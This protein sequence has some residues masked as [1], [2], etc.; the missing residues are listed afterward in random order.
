MAD[1]RA[2]RWRNAALLLG[3]STMMT[4]RLAWDAHRRSAALRDDIQSLRGRLSEKREVIA[5]QR[6]EMAEVG[7]AVERLGRTVGGLGERAAG[8]RRLA[9]LEA[10]RTHRSAI[11]SV[12][13]TLR[14]GAFVSDDAGLVLEEIAWLDGEVATAGDTIAVLS[15]LEQRRDDVRGGVPTLWP[16]HGPVTSPFGSRI[17]PI[18]GEEREMHPGIDISARWGLPVTAA[19][20][21]TIVFA[22]R[23]GGYGGLVIVDHG[24]QISTLYGHLS[25]LYVREGQRVHRGQ[26]LGAVGATGRA[27]GAHVHYEV[28]IAGSPVDP[29]RF[30]N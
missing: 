7:A 16:V 6:D 25:A 2:R 26:P 20:N 23:D 10:S 14:D 5:R 27:T 28:R 17:S 30:L 4:G 29:R 11:R 3:V 18:S 24:A 22:G 12:N 15:A 13:A 9:H 1:G 21:R 19:G 8:A